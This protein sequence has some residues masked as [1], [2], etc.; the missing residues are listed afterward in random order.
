MADL[1]VW[2]ANVAT[3]VLFVLL[4]ALVMLIPKATVIGDAPDRRWFRDLRWW[5]LLLIAIQL[6]IYAIFT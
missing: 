1:P 5:A 2:W 3:V 4:A 6:C